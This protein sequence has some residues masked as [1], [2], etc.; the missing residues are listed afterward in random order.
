[1]KH[2]EKWRLAAT[3]ERSPG[4]YQAIKF[5]GE[6]SLHLER[7]VAAKVAKGIREFPVVKGFH[8]SI[9]ISWVSSHPVTSIRE[10]TGSREGIPAY[11]L[12]Q[13]FADWKQRRSIQFLLGPEAAFLDSEVPKEGQG[14]NTLPN[15]HGDQLSIIPEET[16]SAAASTPPA[17]QTSLH[18]YLKHEDPAYRL[19]LSK[20]S[21]QMRST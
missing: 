21:C 14:S 6:N 18:T 13:D 8:T 4:L 2:G 15:P 7:V 5:Y 16:S 20:L 11:K 3:T 19:S 9:V 12:S 1:M 10:L 17:S